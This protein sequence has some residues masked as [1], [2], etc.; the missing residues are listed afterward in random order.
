[1]IAQLVRP[2]FRYGRTVVVLG[3][4]TLML[5]RPIPAEAAQIFEHVATFPQ[6]G[7]VT[8]DH[9]I[10]I[11][12]MPSG[13][14]LVADTDNHRL[15]RLDVSGN[16]LD[17]IGK[18]G[19]D[20]TG[21]DGDGEF[22]HP[23]GTA[24]A[25][26]GD[27]YVADSGNYRIQRFSSAGVFKKE[28]GSF[29]TGVGKFIWPTSIAFDA[30]GNYYIA[31]GGM[32]QKYSSSDKFIVAYSSQG[33]GMATGIGINGSGHIIATSLIGDRIVKLKSDGA[34]IKVFGGPGLS[35]GKFDQ[36]W[37]VAVENNDFFFVADT[38]N[39]RV[40]RFDA[41]GFV[42][43]TWGQRGG[44]S[45]EFKW[46]KGIAVDQLGDVLVA[47]SANN[48]IQKFR[49]ATAGSLEA[50]PR[51]RLVS[52]GFLGKVAGELLDT[53]TDPLENATVHIQWLTPTGAWGHLQTVPTDQNGYFQWWT[54]A[55]NGSTFR[56]KYNGTNELL[57]NIVKI[58]MTSGG[59]QAWNP[60][61]QIKFGGWTRVHGLFLTEGGSP[62]AGQTV[63][64]QVWEY[65]LR[66]YI[67][68]ATA[69]TSSSG[70]FDF[71]FKPW[72]TTHYRVATENSIIASNVVTKRVSFQADVKS[73]SIRIGLGSKVT[74]SGK[75]LP[76]HRGGVVD[77]QYLDSGAWKNLATA[78]LS[79]TST[80]SVQWTPPSKGTWTVRTQVRE[81]WDH[82]AANTGS[83]KI[84][85][86]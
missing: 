18:N 55:W 58:D 42:V 84:V 39:N 12:A 75:V 73:S 74:I 70:Y 48:R 36:P 76:K 4:L 2:R 25:P 79:P 20:G 49:A 11:T 33:L 17:A 59:I 14:L 23:Y 69:T 13:D 43:A 16:F 64:L 54:R 37:G 7:G 10:G 52:P 38:E 31:D 65:K 57:S 32:V 5:L 9:P 21:G 51:S 45:G 6:G 85:V 86:D 61:S 66:R 71:W 26:S 47:D 29:G 24:I 27:I 34:L 63:F 50:W 78:T 46:P 1:M 80:Y 72:G 62:R 8:L 22:F 35:P 40:Q 77:I 44:G 68:K 60:Y 83:V 3:L 15:V 53:N 19:G 41:N 30:S 81:H 28:W 82:T 67:W 56:T